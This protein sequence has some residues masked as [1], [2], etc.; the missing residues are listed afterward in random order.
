[1]T[2]EEAQDISTVLK[3]G[4]L[5]AAARIIQAEVVGPSLG[6]EAIDQVYKIIYGLAILLVLAWMIIYYGRGWYLCR[7]CFGRKHF[8]YFW[9]FI[10][11]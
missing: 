11:I 9:N 2:I 7:R 1:M 8:I 5:P 6:Q 4:K 3:A 10:I